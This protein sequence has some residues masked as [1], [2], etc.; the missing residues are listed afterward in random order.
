MVENLKYTIT[1]LGGDKGRLT[2]EWENHA[3]S[4]LIAV[5]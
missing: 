2:L 4:V 1:P 5:H 3:A